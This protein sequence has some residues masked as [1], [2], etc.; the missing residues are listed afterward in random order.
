MLMRNAAGISGGMFLSESAFEM[1]VVKIVSQLEAPCH[2][3]L[4]LVKNELIMMAR[5]IPDEEMK[6]YKQMCRELVNCCCGHIENLAKPTRKYLS[7]V[8]TTE[9]SYINT[10]HPDFLASSEFKSGLES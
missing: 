1:L 7:D 9:L 5:S 10:N 2:H 3:C 6:K 8:I 4:Q